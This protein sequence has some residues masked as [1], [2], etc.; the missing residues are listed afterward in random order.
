[1]MELTTRKINTIRREALKS[2]ILLILI[3]YTANI[4]I[5]D[6]KPDVFYFT[7]TIQSYGMVDKII[8][9]I[10]GGFLRWDA[11]YFVH[12]SIYGYTYE[13]SLAFF[14]LYPILIRIISN[15]FHIFFV[16]ISIEA[17]VLLISIIFNVIV[18]V[19]SCEVLYRITCLAFND[20]RF[21]YKVVLLF[22]YNPASI[23]FVAPYTEC[24]YS[25]LTFRVILSCLT[26]FKK[27]EKCGFEVNISNGRVIIETALSA[28]TRSNGVLNIGFLIFTFICLM[29][30]SLRGPQKLH[31]KCLYFLK[32]LGIILF[33]SFLSLVPFFIYQLYCYKQFCT[34]FYV[35]MPK[36]VMYYADHHNYILP[37][38]FSKYNQ[39]WCYNNIPLAYSYVQDHYWNVGF[40]RYYE[41]KQIPNFILAIPVIIIILKNC[42][43]HLR[44]ILLSRNIFHIFTL[45]PTITKSGQLN[46][47]VDPILNVFVIHAF[48]LTIFCL[49]FIHIQ[50][51]TRMLCSAS[52]ILYW[53]SAK[54]LDDVHIE[55][56]SKAFFVS[57]KSKSELFVKMY[58]FS[59]FL[60]G[61]VLFSN[62]LPW[63]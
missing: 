22:C 16:F 9:H 57:W 34:D 40:L 10:F 24:L 5:P 42:V 6:N 11:Q 17:I 61:T 53:Y 35:D 8:F 13:N 21:G 49:F 1:M 48:F 63:T 47:S 12:I 31:S 28:V 59:Y 43:F 27:Y 4:L 38:Q 2:R 50:V 33:F 55:Q 51:S 23:F 58:F 32:Y 3:Q 30:K 7:N 62:F 60:I 56:I 14:P 52:P 25:F 37:G 45:W 26:L 36:K 41:F 54:T 15:F 39:T 29:K 20:T 46:H 18:F 44:I 19:L